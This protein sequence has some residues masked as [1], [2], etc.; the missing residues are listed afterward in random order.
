MFISKCFIRK[1]TPELRQK[2]ENLGYS[3]DIFGIS[4]DDL[5]IVAEDGL[6]FTWDIFPDY[7]PWR[8]ID[9]GE[10][11]DLFLALASLRDD[12]DKFQW[13]VRDEPHE[14]YSKFTLCELDNWE[15]DF[16]TWSTDDNM[17]PWMCHKATSEELIR[18]F[19]QN[20]R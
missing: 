12:S 9:C 14:T 15:D 7:E 6:Y 11:E 18:Y 19:K 4:P 10:N 3:M 2:L 16:Y 5:A 8:S 1:N 17:A 20:E 13:F